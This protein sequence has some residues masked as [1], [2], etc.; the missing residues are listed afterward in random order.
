M[1]LTPVL[2]LNVKLW[3]PLFDPLPQNMNRTGSAL[4]I[5]YTHS[6]SISCLS[7]L[8]A[9]TCSDTNGGR[10]GENIYQCYR[11]VL[12]SAVLSLSTFWNLEYWHCTDPNHHYFSTSVTL[13]RLGCSVSVKS[14]SLK[15]PLAAALLSNLYLILSIKESDKYI[16]NI[17]C[18]NAWKRYQSGHQDG[19]LILFEIN[20]CNI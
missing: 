12:S 14:L 17:L 19:E 8:V 6:F 1:A 5:I 13:L 20:C 18:E 7:A 9:V 2:G 10:P 15:L 16:C 4:S 3:A 11:R